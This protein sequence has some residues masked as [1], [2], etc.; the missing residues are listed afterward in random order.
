MIRLPSCISI[1][2]NTGL[3]PLGGTTDTLLSPI[4]TGQR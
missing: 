1:E 3:S 2:Q 4:H